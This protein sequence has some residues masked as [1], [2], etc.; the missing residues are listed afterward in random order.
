M[1]GVKCGDV[2]KCCILVLHI[3]FY[4][5]HFV[6]LFLM[7]VFII[8]IVLYENICWVSSIIT[9]ECVHDGYV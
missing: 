1:L 9:K 8:Q 4:S 7:T 3:K 2:N 6:L 5:I